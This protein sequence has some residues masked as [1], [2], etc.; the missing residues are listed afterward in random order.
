MKLIK[1]MFL[2]LTLISVM[3][4]WAQTKIWLNGNV[5]SEVDSVQTMN[6]FATVKLY[7]DSGL[8]EL[9]YF[10]V[11]GPFGNYSIKPYDHTRGYYIV[12]ERSDS[13]ARKTYLCPIPEI[14]DNKPFSGNATTNICIKPANP[15]II[16]KLFA[17]SKY[18]SF[19]GLYAQ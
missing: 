19:N 10:V 4:L 17:H 13:T 18:S 3:P 11:C 8:T 1:C 16:R 5:Y 7:N 15:P 12:A 14:W 9:A 6:P 2:A